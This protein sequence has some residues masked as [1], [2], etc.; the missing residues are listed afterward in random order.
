MRAFVARH[1]VSSYFVLAYAFSWSYWIPIAVHGDI[2]R[3][4]DGWP[5]HFPGLLGPA[6]AAIVITALVD[7]GPGLRDL[8]AR[9][10]RWR[11]GWRWWAVIAGTLALALLAVLVPL[12][13]GGGLPTADDFFRYSGLGMIGPL[14]VVVVALVVNGFGEETG[15]RGFA[16]ERL[17]PDHG[18]PWTALVVGLGWA[19]WHIPQFLVVE[20]FRSLGPVLIGWFVGVL[21]GSVVMTYLY[22]E[23]RHSILLV[24]AWHTAFNLVSATEAT[25]ALVGTT[26]SILVIFWALWIV[27]HE[28]ARRGPASVDTVPVH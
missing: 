16:V 25:G 18:L 13:L 5:T 22:R 8:G 12:T 20:S 21:T 7:G 4:G 1:A 19:G 9:M 23:G 15:W 11:V 26:A 27:R 14:G 2:V 24:A 3:M 28:R 6:L 17:L 10:L